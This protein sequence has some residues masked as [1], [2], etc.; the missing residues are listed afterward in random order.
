[1]S[2]YLLFVCATLLFSCTM[3]SGKMRHRLMTNRAGEER[4]MMELYIIRYHKKEFR[5]RIAQVDFAMCC[6]NTI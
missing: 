4:Q 5:I 2:S 1:M 3:Q 6:N